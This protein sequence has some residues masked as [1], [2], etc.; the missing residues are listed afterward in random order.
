MAGRYRKGIAALLMLF[1]AA[2]ATES[3]GRRG[4]LQ[5]ETADTC[6][7]AE[8]IRHI[9]NR[10][11]PGMVILRKGKGM[12]SSIISSR[13]SKGRR[14]SHSGLV[15]SLHGRKVVVH[16]LSHWAGGKGFV[17][18]QTMSEFVN[19]SCCGRIV[20]LSPLPED[21]IRMSR[22]AEQGL[23]FVHQKI[24]FDLHFDTKDSSSLFCNELVIRCFHYAYGTL[25][26]EYLHG[27]D[28]ELFFDTCR[29][30]TVIDTSLTAMVKTEESLFL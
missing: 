2:I 18:T 28:F 12:V 17:V 10:S 14:V 27:L 30:Q 29:F 5:A 4:S 25:P 16:T 20:L 11:Q 8:L 21:S 26:P 15:V 23:Q 22:M 6:E 7:M 3:C 24:P 9:E 19:E 13:Y 1:W